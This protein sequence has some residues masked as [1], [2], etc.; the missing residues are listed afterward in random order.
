MINYRRD[1]RWSCCAALAVVAICAI[2]AVGCGRLHSARE[3]REAKE[4]LKRAAAAYRTLR[5]FSEETTV[6]VRSTYG[7]EVFTRV[8]RTSFSCRQPNRIY[9]ENKGD[10]A[11]VW[12]SDGKRI[13]LYR[14]DTKMY[15]EETAPPDLAAFFRKVPFDV[16]GLNELALLAGGQ[17]EGV[18]TD[19]RLGKVERVEKARTRMVS[20]N[21]ASLVGTGENK[22]EARQTLWIDTKTYMIRRS[23]VLIRR[24]DE[25]LRWEE[26]MHKVEANPNLPDDRFEW[27]P[28]PGAKPAPPAQP[29][30]LHR[31]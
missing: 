25:S 27:S 15:R 16:P 20:G 10:R 29:S 31:P 23:R 9:Y 2:S 12:V 21:I 18:L 30:P 6:R 17:W 22:T 14:P 4:L 24:D 13:V 7:D 28:P 11:L 1:R 26:T 3:S 19:L 8:T 5:S